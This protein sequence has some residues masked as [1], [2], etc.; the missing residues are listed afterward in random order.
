[1]GGLEGAGPEGHH[2][3]GPAGQVAEVGAER[4]RGAAVAEVVAR[5]HH[6]VA[7]EPGA[8]LEVAVALAVVVQVREAAQLVARL[9]AERPDRQV[10]AAPAHAGDGVEVGADAAGERAL[11]HAVVRPERHLV[12]GQPGVHEA[13]RV[14]D[15]LV[16]RVVLVQVDAAGQGEVQRLADQRGRRRRGALGHE[17]RGH[18]PRQGHRADHVVGVVQLAVGHGQPEVADRAAV[19]VKGVAG[20]VQQRIHLPGRHR[21]ELVGELHQ[22]GEP[23]HRPPAD[24]APGEQAV[25]RPEGELEVRVGGGGGRRLQGTAP[26]GHPVPADPRPFVEVRRDPRRRRLGDRHPRRDEP[27]LGEL[28]VAVQPEPCVVHHRVARGGLATRVELVAPHQELHRRTG[29]LR[30]QQPLPEDRAHPDSPSMARHTVCR[31]VAQCTNTLQT[32]WPWSA[33][34]VTARNS[35]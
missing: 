5:R 15:T 2:L 31:N 28:G 27:A 24:L 10:N 14:H 32:V 23:A 33:P 13:E 9:V 26:D 19:A 29:L 25:G 20:L 18:R 7:A 17:V 6:A 11:E 30:V 22:H 3:V 12:D 35:R 1:M 21:G 4:G 34:R 8:L 16:A